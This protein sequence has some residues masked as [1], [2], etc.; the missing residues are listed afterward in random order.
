MLLQLIVNGLLLGGIYALVALAFSL[1]MGILGVLN[2]ATPQIFLIGALVGL[3]LLNGHAPFV[4][5]L[6]GSMAVGGVLSLILEMVG[7]RLVDKSDIVVTLLTTVAFG[8]VLENIV[9]QVWGS[10]AQF[11]PKSDLAS[12]IDLGPVN[13]TAVQLL[14]IGLAIVLVAGLAATV[15]HTALGRSLRAVAQN[16]DAAAI[17]GLRVRRA[18]VATFLI[19]GV[20]AGGAGLLLGLNYGVIS[21]EFG[22][23][24]G[25]SGIAAMILGGVDNLWGAVLAGPFLGLAT[26]LGTSYLGANYN[27]LLV[28]GLLAV[29]LVVRPQGLLGSAR[30]TVNRRV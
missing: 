30:H 5:V 21:L 19:A 8:L 3:T 15:N 16:R 28:F 23:T 13:V 14:G 18:E 25:I 22:I 7:Y 9:E 27:N 11:F 26:V 12:K 6:L 10:Q 4:F 29:V 1:N 24:I 2:L 17:L 20:L